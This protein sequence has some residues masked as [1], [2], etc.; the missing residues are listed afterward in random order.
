ME[1]DET[2]IDES[3]NNCGLGVVQFMYHEVVRFSI[4]MLLVLLF[5]LKCCDLN[6][7]A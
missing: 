3:Y 2:K 7:R 6:I 5:V 1:L 4:Q